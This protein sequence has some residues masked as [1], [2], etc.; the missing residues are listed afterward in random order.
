MKQ[1]HL[2]GTGAVP[3]APACPAPRLHVGG[4]WIGAT[5]AGTRP[6][7]DPA[8]GET[9]ATV[10]VAG[11]A[12]IEAAAHAAATGFAV[13]RRALPIERFAVLT[14]ATALLRERAPAIAAVLTR[15][16]GKPLAEAEREVRL[17][18]E[19]VDFLAEEAKRLAARGVPPRTPGV[20][21]QTVRRV[22]VGPVAAF[23]PWNFPCNLPAR[24]LGGALA[25]GCSVVLKPDERT[26]GTAVELVR[27]FVDA[28]LP[29]GVLNL[30]AG[31]PAAISAALIADGRIAKVSFTG[32][33]A[34]G[35][36]LGELAARYGKRY[37]AELGGHAPVIVCADADAEAIAAMSVAAKYRNAGQVCAS[38]IR[39]LVHRSRYAAFRDAFVAGAEALRVGPGMDPA[40]QMGP[41]VAAHRVHAMQGFV[42]DALAH[43]ARLACGGTRI[44]RPGF[45]YAPTVLEAVPPAA[46]VQ[47][48]EPF[49][50]IAVLDVFD[51]LDAAIARANALPYG[52]AAYG[53]T[54]DLRTAH[55]LADEL[56]AG[57]VGIN[58]FGVSQP[59]TPFGGVKASGI[60]HESGLEGLLG[61]TELK[62]VSVAA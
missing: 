7:V 43:G 27:C 14:R 2:I 11:P 13:W 49:G 26:P 21:S 1:T 5:G 36:Q 46:R 51:E 32:S 22:P 42:D 55:R 52:L 39:F 56:D 15:E 10:P 24:K 23:T 20:A 35:R 48:E 12:E 53:F 60:G 47:R 31:D 3:G 54:H 50:P 19:I 16:Q 29:D 4:R 41:L 59:E 17:S 28:G 37:T 44:D 6:V 8:S 18:A 40:T 33:I 62:F 57:M 34:V 45:F 58:H 25:A 30:V 61:C 9:I 38:P